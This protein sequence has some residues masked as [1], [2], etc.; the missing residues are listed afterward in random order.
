MGR[1]EATSPQEPGTTGNGLAGRTTSLTRWPS[2]PKGTVFAVGVTA[3]LAAIAFGAM[4]EASTAGS[5]PAHPASSAARPAAPPRPAFTRAEEAYIQ[6]LWPIHGEVER[7]AVRV[8]L[9]KIFYR[10]NELDKAGLKARL[11]DALETYRRSDT[12]SPL[13]R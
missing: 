13:I 12:L 11:D 3:L 10:T 4:R 5:A 2:S 9:G 8:S 6:A 7:S 1:K